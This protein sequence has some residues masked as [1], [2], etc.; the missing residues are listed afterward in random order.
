MNDVIKD[1]VM[2]DPIKKALELIKEAETIYLND[3]IDRNEES[4]SRGSSLSSND[5]LIQA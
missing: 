4:R 5:S 3:E 1:H 2:N